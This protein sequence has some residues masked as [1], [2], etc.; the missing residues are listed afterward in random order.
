MPMTV[1]VIRA[2]DTASPSAP[3]TVEAPVNI[4]TAVKAATSAAY[5]KELLFR[6]KQVIA[7]CVLQGGRVS[8]TQ[9]ALFFHK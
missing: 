4:T 6:K 7:T 9:I 1:L 3:S 2:R 5:A 8:I